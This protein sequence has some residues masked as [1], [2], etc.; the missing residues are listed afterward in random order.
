MKPTQPTEPFVVDKTL[1]YGMTDLSYQEDNTDYHYTHEL[2]KN[3]GVKSVRIW[4]HC[5]WFMNSPTQYAPSKLAKMKA[6][7]EDIKK[8]GYQII[9]MNH[10]N[11]HKTGL[12]HSASTTAKPARDLT[13][14]SY[15]LSW[16]NDLE[17]TYYNMVMAFPEIEYWEIDNECNNDDF[18]PQL[19]SNALFT[20]EEKAAI[21]YDMMYFASRGIHRA[22][23]KAK[24]VM[25][26]LV[27]WNAEAFL[28]LLYDLIY[29]N[30]SWSKNPDD[31]FQVACW[32]PYMETYTKKKFISLNN[33]I[34]QIVKKREGK[35]KKVFLTEMGFS[36][37]N[38][39]ELDE[40]GQYVKSM[41][42][43][44]KEDL[45]YVESLHYFR[46]YDDYATTWGSEAEK[47]FGLFYDP[48]NKH[49]SR[50]VD[51]AEPKPG[52]VAYQQVAG[53]T[54][55]LSVY[56]DFLNGNYV[57]KIVMHR[58]YSTM[59]RENTLAAF[60][61][62][63]EQEDVYG[64]ETDVYLTNDNKPILIHDDNTSRVTFGKYN[65]SVKNSTYDELRAIK[66]P[67]INGVPDVHQIP[68][69][70]EYAGVL[71]SYNKQGFLELKEDFTKEQL[72][73]IFDEFAKYTNL[74][75]IT[76]ISFHKDALLR[77]REMYPNMELMLL[78][79]NLNGLDYNE[80]KTNKIGLDVQYES[81]SVSDIENIQ[82]EGI[83]LNLWTVDDAQIADDFGKRSV[84]YIT[85]D[86]I[87]SFK[88]KD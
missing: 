77:L 86:C 34:Y 15:Y 26:G 78:C 10:S 71:N 74:S 16:L 40:I 75:K 3:M 5:N 1:I 31:Y 14:G 38:G 41:Y 81:V 2:F 33:D 52:A 70:E 7:Y 17:T 28:N 56:Q 19:G 37:Y 63:G 80:L 45:Y 22:N 62:A 6:I 65:L 85:T 55:S 39:F 35:D 87:A 66:L 51:L 47:S 73:T 4:M 32:H 46:M 43:A 54:G 67:D 53:G 83:A 84:D 48:Y 42:E 72:K 64:I 18:M 29:S 13:E 57:T 25:G 60:I 59:E 44:A 82:N 49:P 21:Y 8:D 61:K 30:N 23:P 36:E 68:N 69:V 11:F 24:T 20:L 58:G 12:I 50:K 27:V 88:S 79:N 76:T 9:A